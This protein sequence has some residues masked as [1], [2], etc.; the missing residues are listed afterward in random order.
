MDNGKKETT[1]YV[2]YDDF[3]PADPALPEKNLLLAVLMSAMNDLKKNG[4]SSQEALEY[5]LSPEDDYVFSFRA[6]CQFLDLDP[7]K[8]LGL[9][10]LTEE[11]SREPLPVEMRAQPAS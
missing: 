9:I 6:V 1:I 7:E 10:G 3:E 8:L 5:L 2:A 11:P 4:D